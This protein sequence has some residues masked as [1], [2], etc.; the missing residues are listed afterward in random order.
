L[1]TFNQKHFKSLSRLQLFWYV[2][3][4]KKKITWYCSHDSGLIGFIP[5]C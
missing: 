3:I 4:S 1:Y 5:I 2:I